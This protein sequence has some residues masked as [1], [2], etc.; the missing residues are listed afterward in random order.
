MAYFEKDNHGTR[1]D[2]VGKADAYWMN[3]NFGTGKT[4]P[5]LLYAFKE[6]KDAKKALMEVDFIHAAADTGSLISL[7]ICQFGCYLTKGD[8]WEAIIAGSDMTIEDFN[9]IKAV[10]TKN[11]GHGINERVP[12]NEGLDAGPI[13]Q[14]AEKTVDLS[15]VIFKKKYHKQA[16]SALLGMELLPGAVVNGQYTYE[17]Y[18]AP[19]K[20]T[21]IKFL[22]QT[23]VDKPLYYVLVDTPEGSFGKDNGGIYDA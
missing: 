20:I 3:R 15:K 12:E 19:D 11:N 7:K 8:Y 13:Q 4:E 14:A 2:T 23:T 22:E 21:A 10:F 9:N 17:V 18:E 1:Q 16:N 6:E 5:F